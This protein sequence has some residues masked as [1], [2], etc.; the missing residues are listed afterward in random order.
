MIK[1]AVIGYGFMGVSH[2]ANLRNIPNAKVV[3]V[4]DTDPSKFESTTTG[5]IATGGQDDNLEEY[6]YLIILK[7]C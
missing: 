1:I 6:R 3:A 2:V 4:V 7:T 5:N